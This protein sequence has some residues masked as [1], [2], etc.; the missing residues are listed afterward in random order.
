MNDVLL[1]LDG[2]KN[3]KINYGDTDSVYIHNDDNEILKTKSL[4]GK[5]LYQS[6]NDYGN[7]EFYMVCF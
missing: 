2:C 7:E 5:N 1:P 6:K 3:N 4:I